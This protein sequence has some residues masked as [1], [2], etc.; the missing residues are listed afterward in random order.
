[1]NIGYIGLGAMGGPLARR[2]LAGH[3]LH[4]W[5]I[6][7]AAVERFETLGAR[8]APTAAELARRCDVVLLCL[9]RT[10]DVHRVVFGPAGLAEGLSAGKLVI[11]QTSGVPDETREIARQLAERGIDMVDAPVAGGVAAAD[12]GRVTIMASGPQQA[13]EKASPVLQAISSTVIRCGNRLGDGQAVKA[14]NNAMN[15][16]CRLSTLEVV[17]M[18]RKL[19]L[20]LAALTEAINKSTGRSRI[21]Q[22][23]LPAILEGRAATDFALKLMV[24]DVDQAISLAVQAAAPMPIASLTRDLLVMGVNTLGDKARLEDV[25][26]LIESMSAVRLADDPALAPAKGSDD[27][28]SAAADGLV[29]GYVGLGAMGAALARRLMTSRKVHVFDIRPELVRPLEAEGAVAHR[30]LRSLARACDVVMMC[31]PTSAVVRDVL[32]GDGGLV[33][34]LTPGKIVVDQT[35]GDPMATRAMAHELEKLG[36]S[37]VDAPVSGGPGGAAAGTIATLCGGPEDAFAKVRPL[38]ATAGPGVVHFGPSGNG[39]I[40]KLIKNTLGACNRLIAY[41]AVAL[42]VKLGLRLDD[43]ARAINSG[44]GW[45]STFERIMAVLGSGGATANLRIELMVKDL[46]LAVKM[47]MSC[48]ASMV[49]ANAVRNT[50]A[51]AAN[52][53]G[54]D[55]NIDEMARLFER[56]AGVRFTGA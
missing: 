24:K 53:L 23:V 30:D 42:G 28:S 16:A 14:I 51:A 2:L 7:A 25:I 9:P 32:F 6:S 17:A 40:A 44:S 49:Y 37:L 41:E 8:P 52:E 50:V 34:G 54:A 38:L 39:H 56:R 15:A 47:G 12:A 3:T 26:G 20:S 36:I 19:G 1:M 22:T 11:D 43:L 46:D 13:F 29:V 21:S 4:V 18:G 35:T 55:A 10:A 31:L 27:A 48:G 45:S 33:E 5:D